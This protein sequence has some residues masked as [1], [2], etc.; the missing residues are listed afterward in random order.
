[1]TSKLAALLS[2]FNLVSAGDL[3][4]L[5]SDSAI[6]MN[7]ATVRVQCGAASG[8]AQV[9]SY[10]GLAQSVRTGAQQMVDT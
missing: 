8:S 10:V 6:N 9:V 5:G 4:L 1:M 7:G 2:I 3:N